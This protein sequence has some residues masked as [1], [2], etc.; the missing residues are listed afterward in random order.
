MAVPE[1]I[2]I[3]EYLLNQ[4]GGKAIINAQNDNGS[5]LF[6]LA[7]G[8]DQSINLVNPLYGENHDKVT[9]GPEKVKLLVHYGADLKMKDD[10]GS[11]PAHVAAYRGDVGCMQPLVDCGLDFHSRGLCHRRIL[12]AAVFGGRNIRKKTMAR[13]RPTVAL[14]VSVALSGTSSILL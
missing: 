7:T 10:M 5:T 8:F 3:L 1:H 4:E 13:P 2:T 14:V 6:H 12:H 9:Q 11:T